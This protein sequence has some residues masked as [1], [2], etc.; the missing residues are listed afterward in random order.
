MRGEPCEHIF[1]I[2]KGT[3]RLSMRHATDPSSDGGAAAAGGQ[4]DQAR[5]SEDRAQLH[6]ALRDQAEQ[7]RSRQSALGGGGHT[8]Q[9]FGFTHIGAAGRRMWTPRPHAR[10]MTRSTEA[11]EE[12]AAQLLRDAKGRPTPRE[13]AARGV[14]VRYHRAAAAAAASGVY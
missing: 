10:Q 13:R 12:A 3:V 4:P 14:L 11:P 9:G 2:T 5:V 6:K 1:L 8:R 7:S